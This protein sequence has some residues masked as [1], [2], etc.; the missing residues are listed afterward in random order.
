MDRLA[1]LLAPLR[2][3][4]GAGVVITDFDGT[5]AA[6]V[7]DPAAA[8]PVDGAVEVLDELATR[9][10]TVAVVSGRPVAFLAR[11]LPP[12]I[13][14]VGLYGLEHRRGGEAA[15]HPDAA[16]WRPIVEAAT[17]AAVAELPGA[18]LVEPKGL[19]L[20]LHFR[21]APAYEQDVHRWARR[22]EEVDGLA[23]RGAKMSVELHPPLAVDKGTVV[24]RLA[25]GARSI[26]FLGDDVGDLPAFAALAALRAAGLDTVAVA[27]R[28]TEAPAEVLAAGDIVVDGPEGALGVL[29]ALS[30][31]G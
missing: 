27:V 4:P 7:E 20:T 30:R 17:A 12:A 19:S 28:T 5:L 11:V 26:C 8:R 23:V 3:D 16:R 25:D 13:E 18:V 10:R 21:T 1:S 6:I 29:R 22:R 15:D 2:A 31:P 14:L 9:Y 24:H